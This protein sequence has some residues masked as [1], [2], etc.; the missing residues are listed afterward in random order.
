MAGNIVQSVGQCCE[1]GRLQ[2][3]SLEAANAQSPTILCSPGGHYHA[4]VMILRS[5]V[6]PGFTA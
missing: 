3:V 1:W 6:T 4:Q 2:T 5:D